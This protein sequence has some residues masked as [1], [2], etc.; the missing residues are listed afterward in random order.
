MTKKEKLARRYL[1][2][3]FQGNPYP[4]RLLT[5]PSNRRRGYMIRH[6]AR[7]ARQAEIAGQLPGE[8]TLSFFEAEAKQGYA[9]S[10][11]AIEA[12]LLGLQEL[13]KQGGT[14]GPEGRWIQLQLQLVR[15]LQS[16][17]REA[18]AK[19][20]AKTFEYAD[21]LQEALFE[22]LPRLQAASG[23]DPAKLNASL[24]EWHQE[25]QAKHGG[26]GGQ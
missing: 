11:V 14:L 9:E 5:A 8:E 10:L 3:A 15:N 25:Y 7:L 4:M 18:A 6:L 21:A 26:G 1:L 23:G 20:L 16:R 13:D 12:L 19:I 22:A 17:E 24:A 2:W